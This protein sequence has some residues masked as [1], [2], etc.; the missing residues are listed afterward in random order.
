VDA[1]EHFLALQERK[2]SDP[3]K[4]TDDLKIAGLV[5]TQFDRKQLTQPRQV[6]RQQGEVPHRSHLKHAVLAQCL[7]R[8]QRWGILVG[9]SC[10]LWRRFPFSRGRYA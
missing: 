6:D 9:E 8:D 7:D 1:G 2:R 3:P 4:A 10:P 5:P